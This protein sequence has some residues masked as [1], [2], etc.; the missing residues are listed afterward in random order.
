MTKS[1]PFGLLC[2]CATY[3]GL[4]LV[5]A[6]GLPD[7]GWAT[8]AWVNIFVVSGLISAC[9]VALALTAGRLTLAAT[10]ICGLAIQLMVVA[11]LVAIYVSLSSQARGTITWPPLLGSWLIRVWPEWLGEIAAAGIW[12]VVWL[13][14]FRRLAPGF[15]AAARS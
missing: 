15:G 8:S 14:V 2:F 13:T 11:L 12:P 9:A 3:I 10:A 1:L 4:S 7:S 6:W 5:A